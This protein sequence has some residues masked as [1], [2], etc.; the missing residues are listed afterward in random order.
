MFF[1]WM[2]IFQITSHIKPI[3]YIMACVCEPLKSFAV[4]VE[5]YDLKNKEVNYHDE[6][7][8]KNFGL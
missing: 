1:I 5:V 7:K 8:E 6:L 2:Y 4:W 3:H